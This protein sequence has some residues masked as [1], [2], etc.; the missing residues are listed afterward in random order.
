MFLRCCF[1]NLVSELESMTFS[2][3]AMSR[4]YLKDKSQRV[5]STK[6]RSERFIDIPSGLCKL[7]DD[8]LLFHRPNCS[9]TNHLFVVGKG[10]NTGIPL[11]YDTVYKMFKYYEKKAGIKLSPHVLRHTHATSLIKAGWDA[12]FVQKRLGHSQVQ[13]TINT[14][15]HLSDEDIKGAYEKYEQR[16]RD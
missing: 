13:T 2:S 1:L 3:G 16:K 5:L 7:I 4:K 6:S 11:S 14:Y 8:Y 9:D 12:S 15:I 10:K